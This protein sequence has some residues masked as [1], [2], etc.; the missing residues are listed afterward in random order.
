LRDKIAER[1]EQSAAILPHPYQ[2]KG[3]LLANGHYVRGY[4][5]DRTAITETNIKSWN[6]FELQYILD[7]NGVV[8]KST[9]LTVG[10]INI[11][12]RDQP[13]AQ[14]N[15]GYD[16]IVHDPRGRVIYVSIGQKF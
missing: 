3:G 6:R 7:L 11:F 4:T 14:L 16:P 2:I 8:G 1:G 13:L 9:R 5:N 12:D 15:L 10:A